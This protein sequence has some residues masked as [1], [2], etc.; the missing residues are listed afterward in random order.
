VSKDAA[1]DFLGYSN[2]NDVDIL[3][4]CGGIERRGYEALCKA[5]D[6]TRKK[7]IL[8]AMC[9][10]GGDPHAGYRIARALH[11][12]YPDGTIS[13]LV[14]DQ[15]KSAGTLVCIGANELIIADEGELGPLD[16]QVAKPDEMFASG[17]G[18]DIMRGLTNLRLGVLESFK[19]YLLDINAGSG[20]STKMAAEV[21]T[22]L[23]VGTYEPVFAQIDPIRLGEMEAALSIANAYG[24]RLAERSKNLKSDALSKLV[25]SYP[26]HSFVIDRK[27][28]RGL[29]E[30]VRCPSEV[31][32]N[33]AKLVRTSMWRKG[34]GFQST[35]RVLDLVKVIQSNPNEKPEKVGKDATQNS[36]IGRKQPAAKVPRKRVSTRS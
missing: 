21:A 27:E 35:P 6:G 36:S 1:L 13:L 12:N 3:A 4:Y 32:A 28:A 24:K 33:I 30:T 25:N 31:E 23:A 15:C 26:S 19:E 17:S 29:F 20:V 9:T 8:L 22:R 7:N 14:P 5:L 10:F 18:L 34:T 2:V 16:V 11:H